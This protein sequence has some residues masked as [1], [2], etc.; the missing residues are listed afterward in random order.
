MSL[1]A[2]PT[3]G[4]DTTKGQG[5]GRGSPLGFLQDLLATPDAAG[6]PLDGTLAALARS[7]H[8][9]EV[10]LAGFVDGTPVVRQWLSAEG[11]PLPAV[12]WPWEEQP[13]LLARVWQARAAVVARTASGGNFLLAACGPREGGWLLWLQDTAERAWSPE[14]Q[15]ALQL[16]AYALE[17][18]LPP[19]GPGAHAHWQE[20]A[21]LHQRLEDAAVIVGRLAHDFGNVLTGILG[22]TELSLAQAGP[23][24]PLHRYLAEVYQAAQ[25]GARFTNALKQFS[26]RGTPR[27]RPTSLQALLAAEAPRLQEAWG[28]GPVLQNAVPADLPPVA[29]D[30]EPLKQILAPLLENAREALPGE[31]TVTLTAAPR[32]LTEADCLDLLGKA[33]PGPYVELTIHD[34]GAGFTPEARQRVFSDLFFTTKPRRRGMGLAAAYGLLCA[35][36]GGLRLEHGAEG[37]TT[38]RVYLPQAAAPPRPAAGA[39]AS[40]SKAGAEERLLVVDDDPLTLQLMCTTLERAGYRVQAALDGEQALHSYLHSP[41]RFQLVLSDVVMPRMT[42]FDL[43]RTL[44]GRDPEVNVLFT[45]GHIPPG[46]AHEDFAGRDFE[47][48]PKPFRPEGLLRA[49]RAALD[50]NPRGRAPIPATP[51][52]LT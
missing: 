25:Q 49:V 52:P 11:H 34:T 17:R 31:G 33:V 39:A 28:V 30:A 10:G 24:H 3:P 16:S 14:E 43:V 51:E 1:F 35:H 41:E 42:G 18:L 4:N 29:V 8:A 22:F 2:P 47:L 15:A 12:R 20:Q 6:T 50:R 13:E 23:S 19:V 40:A 32:D 46:F 21:R 27:T 45:S 26:Q 48:L 5:D 7:F 38:V 37:G 36:R 9:A 44:L